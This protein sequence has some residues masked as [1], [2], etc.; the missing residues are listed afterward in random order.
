MKNIY[1]RIAAIFSALI[2]LVTVF[3]GGSVIMDLFGMRARHGNYV[4][5]V[6]WANF[7]CAFLYLAASCGFYLKKR[8]TASVLMVAILLLA[9]AF[10]GFL[11][12]IFNDNPY[13]ERTIG[14]MVFRISATIAL[15]LIARPFGKK[16][17]IDH[18]L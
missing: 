1:I 8:W 18:V 9:L 17:T 2:G 16:Q 13:E 4:L 10:I 11:V 6:V 5:F 15:Y 3:M 14:A 12:W 7:I